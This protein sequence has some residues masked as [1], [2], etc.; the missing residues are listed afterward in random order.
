REG[1]VLVA[2]KPLRCTSR[3]SG[4]GERTAAICSTA[5]GIKLGSGPSALAWQQRESGRSSIEWNLPRRA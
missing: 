1:H 5:A 2:G 4:K 3:G